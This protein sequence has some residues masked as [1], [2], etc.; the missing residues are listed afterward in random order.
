MRFNGAVQSIGLL[1]VLNAG[2]KGISSTGLFFNVTQIP[3]FTTNTGCFG[4]KYRKCLVEGLL[5]ECLF[6]HKLFSITVERRR[7]LGKRIIFFLML[8][9]FFWQKML[10]NELLG[11]FFFFYIFL[12]FT[13]F[14]FASK[15]FIL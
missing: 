7:D 5:V 6:E 9:F 2:Q 3:Q 14:F 8:C 1:L 13:S 4:C 12:F 10:K 11:F 15:T